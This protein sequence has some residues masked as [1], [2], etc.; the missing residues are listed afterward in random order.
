VSGPSGPYAAAAQAY[1]NAGWQGVLPLPI[2]EKKPP[3]KRTT[4]HEGHWP[5]WP[6]V[7][8]WSEGPEGRGNIGVWLPR[9]VLGLDI[10][11]YGSKL[12]RETF[13]ALEASWGPLPATWFST[14]R[15]DGVSGIRFFKVPA[16]LK[17]PAG[18]GPGIDLIQHHHRYAAV[19]P[20]IH[21][22]G[23]M[24]VWMDSGGHY[25]MFPPPIGGL[26]ELP[27]AWVEGLTHGELEDAPSA[28]NDLG[29]DKIV[30]WLKEHD[31][32]GTTC[33]RMVEATK[34]ALAAL[35]T[36]ESAHDSMVL[37]V[38]SLVNLVSEDHRGGYAALEALE[39][40]FIAEVADRRS[41]AE[42]LEE[43]QSAV[44]GAVN[45]VSAN[46]S[47]E[48][49]SC[50]CDLE[51]FTPESR[52]TIPR[53]QANRT[54]KLTSLDSIKIRPVRWLWENRLPLGSLTLLGGR[55]QIGK[56]TIAYTLAADITRGRLPGI[57]EGQPRGVIVAG[58]EDSYETTIVP[59]L[60]AA[61]ADLS[62]IYRIDITSVEGT[63][64]PPVLP[65]DL[66]L[67]EGTIHQSLAALILLDPL[68]S[69]LGGN[70]D[71][72]KD[73]EVRRALEPLVAM[74]DKARASVLG[75][76]HVNKGGS[77]DPLTA[78]M[79]SRAFSAVARAVLFAMAD[80]DEEG[81]RLLGQ[82]K[83]NLG[84]E[85]PMLAY[86]VVGMQVAQ[87]GGEAVTTGK[88][89]WL[90]ERAGSVS[91]KMETAGQ[92]SEVRSALADAV[93]WLDYY[94]TS[95]G[96]EDDSATIKKAAIANGHGRDTIQ[97]ARRKLGLMVVNRP[98]LPRTTCWALPA[99]PNGLTNPVVLAS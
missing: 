31:G 60:M 20:S 2:G 30:A 41:R 36:G 91:E 90:G 59:R 66:E 81:I 67:V 9:D 1:W 72:H 56:S 64:G 77:R 63:D 5:S 61:G 47:G 83:S 53:H 13:D 85:Q 92:S 23:R 98:T 55:E 8:A 4:G 15:T 6:D 58:T 35:T 26:P 29:N 50:H 86:R 45:K 93:E 7:M 73:A 65:I 79:A 89:E 43:F 21:P 54:A 87:A 18:A 52:P 32:K 16:G 51:S 97:R 49:T 94:L 46:P 12:G 17:W 19:W 69:R 22:E 24:Y 75:L 40:A 25:S 27:A 37:Q 57:Y 78:L 80:P 34:T 11:A 28:M 33:W 62:R 48:G 44:V 68:L 70:L 82:P 42:A 3:P 38:W 71:T 10:D 99:S 14:N 76:I 74:A 96:G 88:I 84:P 95:K 39:A